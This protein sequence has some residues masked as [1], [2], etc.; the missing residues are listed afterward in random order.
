MQK[1]MRAENPY[2]IRRKRLECAKKQRRRGLLLRAAG[3]WAISIPI[4]AMLFML[5]VGFANCL[6]PLSGQE[7]FLVVSALLTSSMVLAILDYREKVR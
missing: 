7:W 5:P 4:M 6:Y 1:T 3:V 2:K